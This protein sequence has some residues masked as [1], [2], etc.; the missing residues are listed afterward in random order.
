MKILLMKPVLNVIMLALNA[1]VQIKTNVQLVLLDII[2]QGLNV[3]GNALQE[4]IEMRALTSVMIVI[5]IVQNVMVQ[6]KINAKHV[7]MDISC[8]EQSV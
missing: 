6:I 4:N 7:K 8:K 5:I 2:Y 1:Q 3:L